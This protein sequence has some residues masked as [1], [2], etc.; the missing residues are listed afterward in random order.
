MASR[1][2]H[3]NKPQRLAKGLQTHKKH[4]RTQPGRKN[5]PRARTRGNAGRTVANARPVSP[6]VRLIQ[7]L[8]EEKIRFQIVGMSAAILQG[9]IVTTID[10]DVSES[11]AIGA[12]PQKQEDNP[13]RQRPRSYSPHRAVSEGPQETERNEMIL[14]AR[15]GFEP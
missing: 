2:K 5:S 8:G 9:V 1:R 3:E 7:S 6:I 13:P 4:A 15:H 11:P 10:T 14:A 12:H